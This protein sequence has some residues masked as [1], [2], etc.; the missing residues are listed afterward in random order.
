LNDAW[1]SPD[2]A[3]RVAELMPER[4]KIN[5]AHVTPF[6]PFELLPEALARIACGRIGWQALQVKAGRRAVG[7][8][9]LEYLTPMHGGP[10]PD[11]DHAAGHRAHEMFE[12]CDD[13]GGVESTVLA[14]EVHLARR[15]EGRDGRQVVTGVPL[16]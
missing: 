4:G 2:A 13:I 16:P 11:D 12:Q 14:V 3:H 10:I 15:G 9:R 7:E 1:F 6:D 8:E 5:T